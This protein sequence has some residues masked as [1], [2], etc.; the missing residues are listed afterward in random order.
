M[1][2]V[3]PRAAIIILTAM[4]IASC[5]HSSK[6]NQLDQIDP[7][8]TAIVV[9]EETGEPIEGA[10]AI[11]IWWKG[12]QLSWFE[13]AG[14]FVPVPRHV[15]ETNSD[16]EGRILIPGFWED[17]SAP[18]LSVYKCGYIIW[19]QHVIKGKGD[20]TDFDEDNRLVRL[21]RR[22]QDFSFIMHD[23]FRKSFVTRRFFGGT[24]FVQAFRECEKQS[25]LDEYRRERR[26]QK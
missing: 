14:A 13:G 15:E 23:Q 12:K 24:D 3:I 7:G 10:S 2:T 17:R 19:N 25:Y 8:P 16:N 22:P 4:A 18:V 26:S 1:K 21:E 20:R 11:A 6:K 5:S 9:D